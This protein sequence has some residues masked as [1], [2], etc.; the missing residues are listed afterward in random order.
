MS[1]LHGPPPDTLAHL[2]EPTD[3]ASPERILSGLPQ[4]LAVQ[5]VAGLPHSIAEIAAHLHANMRFNLDLIEGRPPAE[6]EDWPRVQAAEW[7]E[8]RRSCLEVLAQ[9]QVL[10]RDPDVLSRVVFAATDSEPGW[11][12]GYKLAVNVAQHNAYH[13][14]QIVTL[15]QLL[16]TW[17]PQQV[18]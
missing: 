2:L 5:R 17:L 9:L 15:R 14:G 8:V 12:A 16:G 10:A 13:L 1:L 6:R 7:P 3:F 18:T 4:H 11:T